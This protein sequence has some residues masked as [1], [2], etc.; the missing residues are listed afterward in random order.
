[1]QVP[2]E[3][4]ALLGIVSR[5][6]KI[7]RGQQHIRRIEPRIDLFGVP[8][9]LRNKLAPM[10]TMSARAISAM[11]SISRKRCERVP[12]VVPRAL[13]FQPFDNPF[14]I[15]CSAGARPNSSPTSIEI[16]NVNSSTAV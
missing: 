10:S 3:E 13:S 9:A 8:E 15:V 12:P 4:R 11:T 14:R 7:Q 5:L 2:H 6:R 16:D 1:M